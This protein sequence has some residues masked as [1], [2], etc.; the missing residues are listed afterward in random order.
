M[1]T[2]HINGEGFP[3]LIFQI[4]FQVSSG[5]LTPNIVTRYRKPGQLHE[6]MSNNEWASK[7]WVVWGLIHKI[8]DVDQYD[9]QYNVVAIDFMKKLYTKLYRCSVTERSKKMFAE[10]KLLL[11][12]VILICEKTSKLTIKWNL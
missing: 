5:K 12:T 6:N 11:I 10:S 9:C 3:D 8:S 4:Y 2:I 7:R 1:F